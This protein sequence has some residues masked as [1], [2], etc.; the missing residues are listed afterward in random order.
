M[1]SGP[2]TSGSALAI[3]APPGPQRYAI[4]GDQPHIALPVVC[5][6][7]PGEK[8]FIKR[9]DPVGKSWMST[10]EEDH[11]HRSESRKLCTPFVPS[12]TVVHPASQ[13]EKTLQFHRRA[14]DILAVSVMRAWQGV[15]EC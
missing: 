8:R 13:A 9:Y 5:D 11:S 14:V 1:T 12:A 4:R 2:I 15:L 6:L 7:Q 3:E 10:T